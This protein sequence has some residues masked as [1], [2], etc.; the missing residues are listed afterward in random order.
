MQGL[1]DQNLNATEA[2]LL[3]FTDNR[4]DASLQAGHFNDF[5]QIA[6]LR[7]ALVQA[8]D[9]HGELTTATIGRHLFDALDL[10]PT[11]FMRDPVER[12]PGYESARRALE[13]LLT[14]RALID[15]TRGWRVNQPNLE[16]AGLLQV[17]Y[18]GLDELAADDALWQAAPMFNTASVEQR[19]Q[20]LSAVLDRCRMELVVEDRVLT[21]AGARDLERAVDYLSEQWRPRSDLPRANLALLPNSEPAAR[22]PYRRWLRLSPRSAI[23][24]YLRNPRT[25]NEAASGPNLSQDEAAAMLSALVEALRGHLFTAVNER[26]GSGVRINGN[27]LRW[28]PGGGRPAQPDPTRVRARYLWRDDVDERPNPFFAR[29]YQSDP[30][31]L[32]GLTS[33]EHTGQV[34]PQLRNQREERFR[35]GRLPALFCSPTMELGID[36]SDLHAVHLRNVPPNPANYAQRAGRAGRNGRAALVTAFAQHGNAHDQYFFDGRRPEMIAGAVQP[37]RIDLANEELLR[38]H[39]HF[40]WMSR[41]N[42][43]LQSSISDVLDLEQDSYP[44]RD[45]IE[46]AARQPAQ[47]ALADAKELIERESRFAGINWLSEEWIAEAIAEAPQRFNEAFDRWRAL[48]RQ[49]DAAYDRAAAAAKRPFASQKKRKAA[50]RRRDEAER[51][52][53]LLRNETSYEESDFYS[54]RYLAGEG[55]LPG[56]NFPKLPVHVFLAQ[57][58]RSYSISCPREIGLAEFG[59]GNTIYY[60]GEKHRVRGVSI[61]VGGL[62]QTLHQARLCDRCGYL[63]DDPNAAPERCDECGVRLTAAHS[64]LRQRLFPLTVSRTE[65]REGIT[66]EEE[67]RARSGYDISVHYRFGPAG[68]ERRQATTPDGQPL[69][70]LSFAPQAS[71]WQINNGYRGESDGFILDRDSG[72]WLNPRQLGNPARPDSDSPDAL[73]DVRPFVTGE[74]NIIVIQPVLAPPAESAEPE[75]SESVWR[76]LCEALRRGVETAFQVEPNELSTHLIGAGDARRIVLIESSDGGA[77]VWKQLQERDGAEF[78]RAIQAAQQACHINPET[79]EDVD[80]ACAAACYRCLLSYANQPDHQHLNREVIRPLLADLANARLV[81]VDSANFP[82]DQW[83][84]LLR[85]C[86][87]D[88][89]RQCLLLMQAQGW[90]APIAQHRVPGLSTQPDFAYPNHRIAIFIDGPC[91]DRPEV[92]AHD[93]EVR[94]ELEDQGWQVAT[95][96]HSNPPA[97]INKATKRLGFP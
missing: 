25:W 77:G 75:E 66:S 88:L 89:E 57:R 36:I 70:E 74:H 21:D 19:A 58:D 9:Q 42:L 60:E 44:L 33:G 56:Y 41:V 69:L 94:E 22:E 23:G 35:E 29:L 2:K 54:Y 20:V 43:K 38:A 73:A 14:H 67:Q 68:R 52:L 62:D 12:G 76:T 49:A 71:V 93:Q 55:F 10:P 27:V 64:S 1:K 7:A 51:E 11:D 18:A 72:R 16:Q 91:H 53:R 63:F 97:Q 85:V 13:D 15:L 80:G 26:S 8:L 95:I 37:A 46:Q 30:A 96:H 90:P 79:G 31:S 82:A 40:N 45:E 32:R 81:A 48:Y 3:S 4:Q 86:D 84:H 87:S 34:D 92:A 5:V 39:L 47:R 6:Q 28:R 50:I 17:T 78:R 61:P 59:P 83:A 24:Q 65:P